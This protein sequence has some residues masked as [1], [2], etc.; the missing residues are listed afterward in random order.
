MEAR[1]AQ[2][3]HVGAPGLV[4]INR[5]VRHVAQS[6]VLQ[7]GKVLVGWVAKESGSE[8][9]TITVEMQRFSLPRVVP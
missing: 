6:R 5:R 4:A 2:F 1:A 7:V 9:R 3:S 8:V